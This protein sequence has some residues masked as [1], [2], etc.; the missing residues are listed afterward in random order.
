MDI[1][2]REA[3]TIFHG[4]IFGSVFLLAFAGGLAG[5]WSLRA[6]LLTVA[7]ARERALR[8]WAGISGMALLA[9]V[10]AVTGIYIVYPWYRAKPPE[11]TVDLTDY[12][13]SLL[14]SDPATDLW[15]RFGMEW[16]EHV[17]WEAPILATVVAF[18]VVWYGRRLAHDDGLRYATI[19][20][21][22]LAFAAAAVAG[23]FGAFITK[24]API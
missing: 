11:G 14:L 8:L 1:T 20:L 5:L 10:T 24:A 3:W 21:F 13:R 6:E 7:G 4:L 15:H 2:L 19:F 23:V 18:I 12:P 17:A 22:I 16:K 9:W